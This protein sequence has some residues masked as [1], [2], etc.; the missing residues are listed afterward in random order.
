[1]GIWEGIYGPRGLEK[2]NFGRIFFLLKTRRKICCEAKKNIPEA[3]CHFSEKKGLPYTIKDCPTTRKEVFKK[4]KVKK[5]KKK[6]ERD[7]TFMNRKKGKCP[8]VAKKTFFPYSSDYRKS[9]GFLLA[10]GGVSRK[11]EKGD[12]GGI[13]KPT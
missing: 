2:R 1:V 8:D 7:E 3:A 5:N 11:G 4:R 12:G 6:G 9:G 10:S 13:Q